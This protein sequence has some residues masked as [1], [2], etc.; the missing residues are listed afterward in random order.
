MESLLQESKIFILVLAIFLAIDLP[1][2]LYI[3]NEMYFNT[4]KKINK[5]KSPKG[6]RVIISAIITYLLLAFGIYYFSVKQNNPLNGAILGLVIYGVYNYTNYA[7]INKYSLNQTM[8]DT[9]WGTLLCGL[10]GYL[11]LSINENFLKA[12]GSNIS[13]SGN[14]EIHTETTVSS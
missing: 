1:M 9:A 4:L 6:F 11:T 10:V 12:P 2:I 7:T 5:K 8:I 13:A 3:N 14:T